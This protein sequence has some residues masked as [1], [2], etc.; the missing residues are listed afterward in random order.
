MPDPDPL[1]PTADPSPTR[2]LQSFIKRNLSN[3]RQVICTGV[4]IFYLCFLVQGYAPNLQ[5]FK[6]FSKFPVGQRGKKNFGKGGQPKF[7]P[8]NEEQGSLLAEFG[9]RRKKLKETCTKFGAFTTK[10]K[11]LSAKKLEPE[12]QHVL[13]VESDLETWKLLKKSSHHQ[14]FLQ[15]SKDLLWCKVPKAASTSWLYAF[16]RMANVA[17]YEIP[18][19]NGMGLHALLREKYPL[20]AKNLYKKYIPTSLKFMVARHPFER[21]M[22]AYLDKLDNYNRDLRFRGGYYHAMY[23]GD[24]VQKYRERYL[25]KFPKNPLFIRKEPSFV[26][27]AHYLI[28]TPL[29]E[30]DE[31]WRPIY[32]LCPPCFFN[33]D[34]VVKMETFDRDSGFILEQK[35]L[36]DGITMKKKHSSISKKKGKANKEDKDEVQRKLFGQLSQAMIRALHDKYRVDFAMFE[37]GI[38]EYVKLGSES[39][40]LMPDTMDLKHP[41]TPVPTEMVEI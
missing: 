9:R 29:T 1:Q 5:S 38:E 12:E 24:I 23:G 25:Q 27:F 40:G 32:L 28:E 14:F 18:E 31:H 8:K 30:F 26:E 2:V 41:G 13:G 3:P 10:E 4:V 37:Y 19:D 35:N 33:F 15:K 7:V 22:S 39:T 11:F 21:L 6:G 34:I 17:E 36:D 20:L 16:L